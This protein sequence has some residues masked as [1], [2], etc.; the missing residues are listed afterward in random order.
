MPKSTTLNFTQN[1]NNVYAN[2]FAF[3][4]LRVVTVSTNSSGTGTAGANTM[5]AGL[6]TFTAAVGSSVLAPSG[7]NCSWSATVAQI[8]TDMRVIS[9]P[10][11]IN[12]GDY[13]IGPSTTP[14]TPTVDTGLTNAGFNLRLENYKELYTASTNDAIVKSINVSSTDTVA[15]TM[16]LWIVGTDNQPVLLGAVSIV[17]RSGDSGTTAATDLLGGTLIPSLTYDANGKRIIPLKAGQ[18][19]AVS[20]PA[21]TAGTQINVAAAIEEY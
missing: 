19:L 20:V 11:I 3:E 13:I 18:K 21:V 4:K 15:R 7:A 12:G 14:N 17:A 2:F 8:N 16:S 10:T 9:Q 6:R 1:I 5:P